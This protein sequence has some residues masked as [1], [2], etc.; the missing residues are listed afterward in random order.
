MLPKCVRLRFWTLNLEEIFVVNKADRGGADKT[1]REI[2]DMLFKNAKP[3][4]T[5]FPT[6]LKTQAIHG[7]G[8]AELLEEIQE[9]PY[10]KL[11]CILC[12]RM[13]YRIATIVAQQEDAK[14][15]V[16]GEN[17]GQVASQTLTNLTVLD[18]ATAIP[19]FRPLIGSDKT[20]TM[21]LARRIGTYNASAQ[22]VGECFAVP[23]R[24]A[25]QTLISEVE[26]AE[27]DLSIDQLVKKAIMGIERLLLR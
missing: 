21:E 3:D 1:V 11:T 23:S 22:D 4:R 27:A 13:M 8:I 25:I 5:K 16:T 19:V 14:A 24:P 26:K 2:E 12:K 17:L 9:T 10:L 18:Q 6:V 7:D 15:L 20:E